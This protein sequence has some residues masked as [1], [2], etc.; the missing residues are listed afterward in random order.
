MGLG[1]SG[2]EGDDEYEQF[3]RGE[4]KAEERRDGI[5]GR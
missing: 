5:G 1:V 4:G 2:S 3:V